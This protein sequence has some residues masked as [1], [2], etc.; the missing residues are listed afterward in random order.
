MKQEPP[1]SVERGRALLQET[2]E[3]VRSGGDAPDVLP[4]DRTGHAPETMRP[5]GPAKPKG[6][7]SL[8]KNWKPRGHGGGI[9]ES[10]PT[11]DR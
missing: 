5:A 8:P 4:H 10:L 3:I 1:V 11:A 2:L 9:Y 7:G 6:C